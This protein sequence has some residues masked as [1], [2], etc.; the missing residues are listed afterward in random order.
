MGVAHFA[1]RWWFG[2]NLARC[3]GND[4]HQKSCRIIFE[5]DTAIANMSVTTT[6]NAR[7]T[8]VRH[9]LADYELHHS[10]PPEHEAEPAPPPNAHDETVTSNP[11]GWQ[12]EWRRVPAHRPVQDQRG[13][14]RDSYNSAVERNFVRVMFGGVSFLAV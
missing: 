4:H 7:I 11:T 14:M 12:T 3:C 10:D 1:F 2:G 8:S 13:E 9:I 5:V 6:D